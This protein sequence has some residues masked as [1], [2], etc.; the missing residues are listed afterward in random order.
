MAKKYQSIFWGDIEKLGSKDST[1][2]S[3][4]SMLEMRPPS[5]PSRPSMPPKLINAVNTVNVPPFSDYLL[6][7]VDNI[8][9]SSVD[10]TAK[11]INFGLKPIKK[12]I[13]EVSARLLPNKKRL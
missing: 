2:I 8:W 9:D 4:S 3:K 11:C 1:Q 7:K 6:S 12:G 5:K 10:T 13:L